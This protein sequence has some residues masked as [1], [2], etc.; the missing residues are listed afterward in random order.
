MFEDSYK[1][2]LSV[3]VVDSIERLLGTFCPHRGVLHQIALTEGVRARTDGRPL[4][5]SPIGS[6][7]SNL[8]L[9]TLFVLLKKVPQK[10]PLAPRLPPFSRAPLS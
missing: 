2:L 9:Q 1:S 5:W 6:R 8:V 10:V 3:I 4:D 7:F